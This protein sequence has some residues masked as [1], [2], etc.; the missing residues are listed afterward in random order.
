MKKLS[1]YLD[2]S[3]INFLFADDA[4]EKRDVTIDLFENYIKKNIYETYISPV[5]IDE[6]NKFS[7]SKKK[8]RLL[9]VIKK[10]KLKILDTAIYQNEIENISELYIKSKIIPLNKIEDALHIAISTVFEIDILLSWNYKHLANVKKE[11]EIISINFGEGF[12]KHFRM[13]TP[14]EVLYEK[15]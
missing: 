7:D 9:N 6:I 3:V 10:Y 12:T 13:T 15:D 11:A 4:P 14:M 5:V 8:E 1:I 2:T